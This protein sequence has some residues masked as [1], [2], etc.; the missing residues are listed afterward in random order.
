MGR[1]KRTHAGTQPED[2][3]D[4]GLG[5][6]GSYEDEEPRHPDPVELDEPDLA[7][8]E[9]NLDDDDEGEFAGD[10]GQDDP[11]LNRFRSEHKNEARKPASFGR[12]MQILFGSAGVVA[13]L[14]FAMLAFPRGGS[15][16]A[17]EPGARE[18]AAVDQAR[19][20][21]EARKLI[22]R[23]LARQKDAAQAIAEKRLEQK[24]Q[25][26][27]IRD[28]KA[29]KAAQQKM[30]RQQARAAA[31]ATP[32]PVTTS[33]PAPPTYTDVPPPAPAATSAP[34][35]PEPSQAAVNQAAMNSSTG[36]G[37]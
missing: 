19:I 28:A 10:D 37:Q 32:A 2:E 3:E 21:A 11:V 17:T 31:P 25:L 8:R 30:A 12:R 24:K 33:A 14:V 35:T 34:P 23:R 22:E 6:P 9:V 4:F 36:F 5:L 13:L 27:A 29:R 18:T 1:F 15:D 16:S 20:E 7:I 26:K